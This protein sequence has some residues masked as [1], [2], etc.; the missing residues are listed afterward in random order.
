MVFGQTCWMRSTVIL[1]TETLVEALEVI[2]NSANLSWMLTVI[3]EA[4]LGLN[5]A[6][7]CN[8]FALDVYRPL[9]MLPSNEY[10]TSL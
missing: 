10:L 6:W 8:G 3:I 9:L 4:S 7:S 1:R 5:S 2:E